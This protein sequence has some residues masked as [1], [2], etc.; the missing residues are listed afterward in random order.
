MILITIL[1]FGLAA[2]A[3]VAGR[4]AFPETGMA[5]ICTIV[6]IKSVLVEV[7]LLT[8]IHRAANTV[9]PDAILF[10]GKTS[11][12]ELPGSDHTPER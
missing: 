8:W 11:D 12:V 7:V 1:V 2:L 6:L 10:D 4:F 9:P 3:M 5:K